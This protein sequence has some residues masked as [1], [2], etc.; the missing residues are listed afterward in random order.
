MP[1]ARVMG[2]VAGILA[3]ALAG[4]SGAHESATIDPV[5]PAV[6]FESPFAGRSPAPNL[7]SAPMMAVSR[8]ALAVPRLESA[9]AALDRG[10]VGG[11]PAATTPGSTSGSRI[12]TAERARLLLR[13]LTVP[14]W[15]QASAGRRTS[16][17]VFALV[18]VGVWGSFTAFRIQQQM[19]RDSY[20]RTARLLG[21]IDLRGRD[22]EFRR[23]VG[24]FLSSDEYNRLVVYRDAANLYYDHPVLYRQ[25]IAEHELR[26]GDTWSWGTVDDLLAYRAQRKNTQR[27]GLRANT[28]L[29][30]AIID[31]L[32]SAVH[33]ARSSRHSGLDS[34]S[35]HS[36][37]LEVSP[38]DP[39]DAT[40]FRLGVRTRF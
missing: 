29:A 2:I 30:L 31:R 36:W 8:F 9:D 40:A 18:E 27:A 21:G 38:S 20:E 3:L 35:K 33:A 16:A 5:Q 13:S 19:R 10:G 25:Y 24:S 11:D 37:N 28:A 34:R 7:A 6:R 1:R 23:I 22:E 15:G 26:G 12:F 14:G 17:G 39:R 32:V 4:R